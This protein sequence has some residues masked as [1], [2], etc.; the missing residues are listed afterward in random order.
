M[1][2]IFI[3]A[4]FLIA[5]PA[6]AH[7]DPWPLKAKSLQQTSLR[8]SPNLAE[9]GA[10]LK[11]GT[12]V[13]VEMCFHP[14]DKCLVNWSGREG[15]IAAVDF[16]AS[17][18]GSA[19][20][21][22]A[23]YADY[24]SSLSGGSNQPTGNN[25]AATTIYAFGDSLTFG[26]GA[27]TPDQSYPKVAARIL[28][29]NVVNAGVSAETSTEIAVRMGAIRADVNVRGN[30]IP[31]KGMIEVSNRDAGPFT[32][33]SKS[34]MPATIAG[35]RGNLMHNR[36]GGYY[37]LRETEG[38]EAKCD[39]SCEI[40]VDE[41]DLSQG[42]TT[43]IWAGRNG[44]SKNHN[45]DADIAAMVNRVGHDRYLVGS[46]LYSDRDK[47]DTI[48]WIK[49]VNAKLAATY[50][51]RFVDVRTTLV[52]AA[53]ASPDDRANAAK[54]ITPKSLRSDYLHLNDRGY[55][56]AAQAFAAATTAKG[57]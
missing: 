48:A 11:K 3:L 17:I 33:N 40:R 26:A 4:S 45:V 15:Y 51:D 25:G 39:P 50:G 8:N 29:R 57:W 55:A 10:V 41:S 53:G 46:I 2:R 5:L 12:E 35:V 9:T 34:M 42:K 23:I 24:W 1:H 22:K 52:D 56:I 18:D 47:D 20:T 16:S 38:D 19:Q 28:K 21:V 6:I 54:G 36:S 13:T 43:W 44:P 7:S 37:F 14:G 31:R 30:A 49:G 32:K 27:T